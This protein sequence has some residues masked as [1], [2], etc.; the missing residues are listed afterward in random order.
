MFLSRTTSRWSSTGRNGWS[1]T[2]VMSGT[3]LSSRRI[4]TMPPRSVSAMCGRRSSSSSVCPPVKR[5]SMLLTWV[6]GPT[7]VS[8]SCAARGPAAR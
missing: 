8:A 2:G 6:P 3:Q 1:P 4:P 5:N 7:P